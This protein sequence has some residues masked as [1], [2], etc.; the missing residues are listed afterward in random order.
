MAFNKYKAI[1]RLWI[2]MLWKVRSKRSLQDRWFRKGI[3]G[4]PN[5]EAARY[6]EQQWHWESTEYEEF[7]Q[8]RRSQ[9]VTR[10]EALPQ[11]RPHEPVSP[12]SR[13]VS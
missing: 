2:P 6:I 12:Q 3:A 9:M 5:A 7:E 11:Q 10:L 13:L 8:L 1:D 4:A